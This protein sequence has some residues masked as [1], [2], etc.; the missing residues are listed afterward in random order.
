LRIDIFFSKVVYEMDL[1]S[2]WTFFWANGAALK[3]SFYFFIFLW[4]SAAPFVLRDTSSNRSDTFVKSLL[5]RLKWIG[6]DELWSSTKIYRAPR[7]AAKIDSKRSESYHH[8][9]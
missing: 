6:K 9:P 4:R 5:Y 3:Y 8:A 2:I 7:P 1:N